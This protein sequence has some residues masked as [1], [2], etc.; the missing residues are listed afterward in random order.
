MKQKRQTSYNYR[1]FINCYFFIV[2]SKRTIKS[3][4]DWLFFVLFLF[5]VSNLTICILFCLFVCL[6]CL[7]ELI[8]ALAKIR[9]YRQNKSVFISVCFAKCERIN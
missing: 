8:L 2:L 3:E 4:S 5:I 6:F 1:I 9:N 7:I